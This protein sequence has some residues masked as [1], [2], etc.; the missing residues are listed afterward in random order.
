MLVAMNG[1]VFIDK[2]YGIGPQARFMPATTVPNFP[3]GGLSDAFNGL[4]AATLIHDGLLKRDDPDQW[5]GKPHGC[6]SIFPIRLRCRRWGEALRDLVGSASRLRAEGGV[7]MRPA[8]GA[9]RRDGARA[10][11]Y[12]T[13]LD[14]P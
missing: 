3:L 6:S 2:S 13:Y 7:G 8:P 1:K 4:C 14:E 5:S 9:V 12:S 10:D 11:G